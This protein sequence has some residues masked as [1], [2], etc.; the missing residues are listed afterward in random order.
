MDR[1]NLRVIRSKR[2]EKCNR[3][4][5]FAPSWSWTSLPF[6]ASTTCKQNFAKLCDFELLEEKLQIQDDTPTAAVKRGAAVRSVKVRG[7]LQPFVVHGSIKWP[8]A[9]ISKVFG[10]EEKFSFAS[11]P[12]QPVH[13]T[14]LEYGRVLSYEARKEEVL[15]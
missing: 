2:S 4:Q 12:E 11:C 5:E 8:W 15:S 10:K 14:N 1:H 13:S 3:L 7:R 6:G 9:E